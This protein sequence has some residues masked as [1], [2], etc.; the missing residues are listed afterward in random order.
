M[1]RV[2]ARKRVTSA[3]VRRK[4]AELGGA[5]E[6]DAPHRVKIEMPVKFKQEYCSPLS[7]KNGRWHHTIPFSLDGLDQPAIDREVQRVIGL[8][9]VALPKDDVPVLI[10]VTPANAS[11]AR[12]TERQAEVVREILATRDCQVIPAKVKG[13]KLVLDEV[14]G[15]ISRDLKNVRH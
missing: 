9:E 15:R 3:K 4:L 2:P 1:A 12:K 14:K 7:W 13:E 8:A 10:A 5:L 6:K 11:L